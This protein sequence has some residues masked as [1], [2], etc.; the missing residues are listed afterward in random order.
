MRK[1]RSNVEF[2]AQRWG[3]TDSAKWKDRTMKPLTDAQLRI[4]HLC[5]A[6]QN[7]E[8]TLDEF[9]QDLPVILDSR[10]REKRT[11]NS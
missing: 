7:G 5:K 9:R 10:D 11:M 8:I 2:F 3:K 4:R 1:D 6:Y